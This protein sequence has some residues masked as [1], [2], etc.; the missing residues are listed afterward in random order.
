VK[1]LACKQPFPREKYPTKFF[2]VEQVCKREWEREDDYLKNKFLFL[3][4][5]T[6][7]LLNVG[8]QFYG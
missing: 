3:Q 6:V 4:H 8:A 5:G 7:V 2:L 1:G